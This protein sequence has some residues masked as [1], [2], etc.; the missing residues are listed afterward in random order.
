[1]PDVEVA[2]PPPAPLA[3]SPPAAPAVGAPAV[4]PAAAA[5]AGGA[6][7]AT[8]ASPAAGAAGAVVSPTAG[9]AAALEP[10]H[11]SHPPSSEALVPR[12]LMAA[13]WTTHRLSVLLTPPS[14]HAFLHTDPPASPSRMTVKARQRDV[15]LM[16]TSLPRGIV[17]HAYHVRCSLPAP[18]PVTQL[19]LARARCSPADLPCVCCAVAR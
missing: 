3:L 12:E 2:A 17:V 1:V 15:K 13:P 6:S 7:T 5:V 8:V 16:S 10:V 9:A 18:H 11:F 4:S 14:D 19:L